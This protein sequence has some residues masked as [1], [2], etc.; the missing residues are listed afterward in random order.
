M[1]TKE[2]LEELI[3]QRGTIW[4][5][6]S[7]WRNCLNDIIFPVKLDERNSC[8]SMPDMSLWVGND[9][10][11]IN[12]LYET[13]E[14]AEWV[15]KTHTERT[16]RFEPPMWEDIKVEDGY[17][18]KFFDA[19]NEYYAFRVI[20]NTYT[21]ICVDDFKNIFEEVSTKENYEKACEI[22]RNLFKGEK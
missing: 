20:K 6:S 19:N 12:D 2:R 17:E 7:I 21:V 1:M 8:I 3:K 5:I 11:D 13:K 4:R 14:Q 16:E 9:R 15:L 10:F 22:V 18:F